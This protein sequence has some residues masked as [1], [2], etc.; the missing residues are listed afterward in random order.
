MRDISICLCAVS[1]LV[2]ICSNFLYKIWNSSTATV[3]RLPDTV[4]IS[5]N[6]TRYLSAFKFALSTVYRNVSKTAK[7][8]R[9]SYRSGCGCRGA[10]L[11]CS[12]GLQRGIVMFTILMPGPTMRPFRLKIQHVVLSCGTLANFLI[13]SA[14]DYASH[15]HPNQHQ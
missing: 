13:V 1:C 7:N 14:L 8:F 12:W 2:V 11:F 15:W 10:P 9:Q 5:E 4:G 6:L 3:Q